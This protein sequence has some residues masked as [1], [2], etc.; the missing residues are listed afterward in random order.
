MKLFVSLLLL[1]S[2]ATHGNCFMERKLN[3]VSRT[4]LNLKMS[5]LEAVNGGEYQL[6]LVRHGESTWNDLNKFTGWYDCQ[7]S[8]KGTKEAIAAGKLLKKENLDI[9][10]AYSSFLSRA[11]RTM[12]HIL[13]ENQLMHVE[14]KPAWQLNE[15]HY[16]ALQGLDK[17]ETVEK[18]G[19]DQVNIWRRS[20][21][22]PPPDCK[23][24]SLMLPANDPRYQDIEGARDIKA[25]SLKLTLDRVLP[26]WESDIVPKLKEK[27]KIMIAAHG[28]SLRALVKYLDDIPDDVIA[29]LNIPTGVPLVYNL[30]KDLKPI[31]S[32]LAMS[33]LQGHYLGDQEEIRARIE[34]VKSQT[35]K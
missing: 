23:S 32:K 34:G 3:I 33:P 12:W 15:R 1:F 25:E 17:K 10:F 2:F 30:D 26:F 16:G 19:T 8:E 7:L 4:P 31:A 27:K 18:F 14:Y 20:Y 13:E 11:I 28:N 24:D 21:D 5:G 9:K 22:I 29:G 35:G 6:V